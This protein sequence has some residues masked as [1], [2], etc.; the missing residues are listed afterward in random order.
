M[1]ITDI[2]TTIQETPATDI[3]PL[4]EL[5]IASIAHDLLQIANDVRTPS[6]IANIPNLSPTRSPSPIIQPVDMNIFGYDDGDS[7]AD[8]SQPVSTQ[9][10]NT[11][12]KRACTVKLISKKKRKAKSSS[13]SS[14]SDNEDTGDDYQPPKHDNDD[15]DDDTAKV[16]AGKAKKSRKI[17]VLA[18]TTNDDDNDDDTGTDDELDEE[19][20]AYIAKKFVPSKGKSR[21]V[22]DT[23]HGNDRESSTSRCIRKYARIHKIRL[24]CTRTRVPDLMVVDDEILPE[25]RA[26]DS[27]MNEDIKL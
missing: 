22:R 7:K 3:Q 24:P 26:F 23:T 19:T 9:A 10:A 5:S 6:N 1:S 15:D 25:F 20:I 17:K 12:Q 14:F 13:I 21:F 18:E 2:V 11:R 4:A 8:D 16:D 27:I